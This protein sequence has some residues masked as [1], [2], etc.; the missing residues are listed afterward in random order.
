MVILQEE[1]M[2]RILVVDDDHDIV[3]LVRAY[4]EKANYSVLTGG[5][6]ISFR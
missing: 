1:L 4:L 3:R 6:G 2:N 5:L